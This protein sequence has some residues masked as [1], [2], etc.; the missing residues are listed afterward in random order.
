MAWYRSIYL[1]LIYMY[2]LKNVGKH[3]LSLLKNQ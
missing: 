1:A 2:A 3:L